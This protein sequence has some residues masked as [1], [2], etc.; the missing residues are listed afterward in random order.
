[1]KLNEHQRER[2]RELGLDPDTVPVA[3]WRAY[4]QFPDTGL[5]RGPRGELILQCR[6]WSTYHQ[7]W[8]LEA[9]NLDSD[10]LVIGV[11]T[12]DPAITGH[13]PGP[14]GGT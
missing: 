1:M 6:R 3:Q 2:L 10:T 11:I 9:I 5:G 7:V 12:I 8:G 13:S 14:N 4:G